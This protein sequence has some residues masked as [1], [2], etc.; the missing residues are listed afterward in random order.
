[1]REVIITKQPLT[2]VGNSAIIPQ[3]LVKRLEEGRNEELRRQLSKASCPELIKIEPAPW[4]EIK[5]NLYKATFTWNK[6]K[7]PEIVD[8]DYNTI[9]NQSLSINSIIIAKLIFVQT[10]YS[11]RDQQSIGTKLALKGLQ[12]VTERNLG[13][14][15][16]D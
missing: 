9:K 16:L 4:K 14:P 1:M 13:D 5:H 12:I 10:G 11:A 6:E 3:E 7:G 15:W 2:L 8:Q